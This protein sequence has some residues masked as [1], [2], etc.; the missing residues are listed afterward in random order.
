MMLERILNLLNVRKP[1]AGAVLC[2]LFGLLMPLAFAP[3]E[4]RWIA[5]LSLAG[6]LLLL[7]DVA[8]SRAA[9]RVFIWGLGAFGLGVSWVYNSL[10]DFGSASMAV[11]ALIT[12]ALVMACSAVHAGCLLLYARWRGPLLAFNSLLLFPAAWTAAEWLRSWILTGF[13]WLLLGYSQV[14]TALSGYA[15]LVGALGI[16]FAVAVL[17]G[18]VAVLLLGSARARARAVA[19]CVAL[20]IPLAG[21]LLGRLQWVEPNGGRL[22]VALIQ[23][24][25]PQ[26]LKMQPEKLGY[27]IAR[28][29]ELSQPHYDR[30]LILW[31][32]T[33][34]PSFKH[35]VEGALQP[36]YLELNER[37]VE[38][39]TGIFV[40]DFESELYYNSLY[41]L[42]TDEVYSKQHLVP[43]GE[44][45]PLRWLLEFMN[46]FI[47]IP[48][49]D[50]A[51]L[52]NVGLMPV[53]GHTAGLS[54]CYESAYAGIFRA[55]L[56][57]AEFFVNASND[58]WF[59]DSLAPHQ[60]L[61]IARMRALEAGRYL[62]RATN[63][64]ISAIIGPD[65]RI[66][67]RS[68]QFVDASIRGEIETLGGTTP[69]AAAGDWPVL[70]LIGSI[71]LFAFARGRRR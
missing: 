28:Y 37:G 21:T 11:S 60:H 19:V 49:S 4:W 54:I 61:E 46:R 67:Q 18:A 7:R 70:L 2:L 25:I 56:P 34:V 52:D 64:G 27:N 71:L 32:E 51:P 22:K 53:A 48:M 30:D 31:P 23:G 63:N 14:D 62:L 44:Y 59:G 43:F 35:R 58:A 68:R 47:D 8:P 50:I 57:R 26:E 13:P 5:V 3:F 36:F 45:M 16:G 20:A 69:Y 10:H 17:A 65:G 42:G 40:Y 29:R 24:N 6:L 12:A 9:L 1:W 39:I 55:Q 41:K 15:R 38:L 33:A 66:R